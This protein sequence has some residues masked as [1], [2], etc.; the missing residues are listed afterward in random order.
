MDIRDVARLPNVSIATVSRTVNGVRSVDGRLA[1][2]VWKTIEE[3]AYYPNRSARAIRQAVQHLAALWHTQI[4]L[5][6]GP[7][8]LR[9]AVARQEAF[10]ASMDEIGL[11]VGRDFV[12]QGDH[13]LEGGKRAFQKLSRLPEPPTALLCSNDMTAIGV[14]REAFELGIRVPE[15]LSVIGFDDIRMAGFLIPPLTTVQMS[16]SELARLAFEGLINEIRNHN[17]LP[18]GTEYLL[19]TRLILKN[20][21]TLPAG[22]ERRKM[23]SATKRVTRRS[24][25]R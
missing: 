19:K 2:R 11:A 4:G 25:T 6:S 1:K 15:D 21:A 20:S 8:A 9:S 5:I 18:E 17:P 10:E 14:M 22:P 24:A 3:L 13:R 23:R 16:Q 7:L 12:V